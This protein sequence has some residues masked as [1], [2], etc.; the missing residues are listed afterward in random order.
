MVDLGL[1]FRDVFLSLP[2]TV[3]EL[4]PLLRVSS[5]LI[6]PCPL[7]IFSFLPP[8][9]EQSGCVPS[10]LVPA[11][12]NQRNGFATHTHTTLSFSRPQAHAQRQEKEQER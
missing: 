8:S 12:F 7:L 2:L 10:V 5:P 3:S 1:A 11:P 4:D 6:H 9:E